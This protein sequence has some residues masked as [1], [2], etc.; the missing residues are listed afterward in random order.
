MDVA[1]FD[2]TGK[3]LSVWKISSDYHDQKIDSFKD[4]GD[5]RWLVKF[6]S[7]KSKKSLILLTLGS[8]EEYSLFID[9]GEKQ[10][11][12][13]LIETDTNE[14]KTWFSDAEANSKFFILVG[15]YQLC[16]YSFKKHKQFE[17]YEIMANIETS[18]NIEKLS[19]IRLDESFVVEFEAKASWCGRSNFFL[20]FEPDTKQ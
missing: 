18:T 12:G 8:I 14:I 20:S 16:A 9:T 15:S 4:C 6:E 3:A 17:R 13:S 11:P 2:L 1:I 10:I 5:G 7:T 19:A